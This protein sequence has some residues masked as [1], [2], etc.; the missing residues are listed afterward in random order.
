VIRGF[1]HE[2]SHSFFCRFCVL[3]L[4]ASAL[5]RC[6]FQTFVSST[7]PVIAIFEQQGKKREVSAADSVETV[8]GEIERIFSA[9]QWHA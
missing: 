3:L 2:C 6:S 9:V 8:W 1:I 5:L 4:A 7:Q